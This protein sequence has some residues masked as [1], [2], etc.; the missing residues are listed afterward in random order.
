MVMEVFGEMAVM[1]APPGMPVPT[2]YCPTC[3]L[4]VLVQLMTDPEDVDVTVRGDMAAQAP[5]I[6]YLYI[7][8]AAPPVTNN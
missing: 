6:E 1:I 8:T 7:V 4:L 2:R 3:A 5:A